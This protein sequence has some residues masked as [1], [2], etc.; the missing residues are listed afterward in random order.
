MSKVGQVGHTG[1]EVGQTHFLG[2]AR[3][4]GR[5]T[6]KGIKRETTRLAAT[7][8]ATASVPPLLIRM[9]VSV[10]RKRHRRFQMKEV[11]S[12]STDGGRSSGI[13]F[14][15]WVPNHHKLL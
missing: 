12:Y 4:S 2:G 3:F 14:Q 7:A 15:E 8:G 9:S 5:D 1:S 6:Q 13:D 11:L 10:P